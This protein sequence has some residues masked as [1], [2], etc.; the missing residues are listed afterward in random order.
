MEERKLS[1]VAMVYMYMQGLEFYCDFNSNSFNGMMSSK[2][3][4]PQRLTMI[5][6]LIAVIKTHF[7]LSSKYH[8]IHSLVVTQATSEYSNKKKYQEACCNPVVCFDRLYRAKVW[9]IIYFS[10]YLSTYLSIYLFFVYFDQCDWKISRLRLALIIIRYFGLKC[11]LLS[12]LLLFFST[13]TTV[14][15][16][17]I[18]IRVRTNKAFQY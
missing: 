9:L 14:T 4:N 3:R 10:I 2:K 1:L 5:H 16:L 6:W 7:T 13:T 18:N 8:G 17:L 12:S 11:K 15:S